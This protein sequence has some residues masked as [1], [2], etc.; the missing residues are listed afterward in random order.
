MFSVC[1][2]LSQL[3]AIITIIIIRHTFLQHLTGTFSDILVII[4]LQTFSV[5]RGRSACFRR[6]QLAVHLSLIHI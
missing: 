6:G 3:V 5:G 4:F 1:G 2:S